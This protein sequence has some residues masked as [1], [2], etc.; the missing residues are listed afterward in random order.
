MRRMNKIEQL[1]EEIKD[2]EAVVRKEIERALFNMPDNPRISR[3]HEQPRCFIMS[4]SDLHGPWS[5][6]YYDYR[7]T[8]EKLA[9]RIIKCDLNSIGTILKIVVE[10]GT[11]R[12]ADELFYV[13][14]DIRQYINKQF[15]NNELTLKTGYMLSGRYR[16][17]WQKPVKKFPCLIKGN[18]QCLK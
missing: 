14:T 17:K 10:K 3:I 1:L 4:F 2:K 5:P 11:F 9:E 13:H 15:F 12:L 16:R 18:N 6:E 7:H 8:I